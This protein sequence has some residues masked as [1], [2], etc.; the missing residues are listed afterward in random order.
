MEGQR[1]NTIFRA[2]ADET[3]MRILHL[4]GKNEICVQ[5]LVMVL[6]LPQ[7]T[8][9][10]HLGHLRLAGLVKTRKVGLWRF[11]RLAPVDNPIQDQLFGCLEQCFE[12]IPTL[13]ADER[14]AEELS[15]RGE[16]PCPEVPPDLAT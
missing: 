14:R 13:Q 2:F 4:V 3:R 5:G 1:A 12:G 9:S 16:I 8:V 10:R 11:Y 6:G 7:P 15:E